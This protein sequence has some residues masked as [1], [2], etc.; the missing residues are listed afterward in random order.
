MA[1]DKLTGK[2]TR[3]EVT[4]GADPTPVVDPA[5]IVGIDESPVIS[6]FDS[7]P[8]GTA[9]STPHSEV[10]KWRVE[11]QVEDGGPTHHALL[12]AIYADLGAGLGG[13]YN[14]T[15]SD[16]YEATGVERRVRYNGLRL[17]SVS[18]PTTRGS[19]KVVT[20]AGECKASNRQVL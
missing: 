20:I 15:K 7:N 3:V 12:D 19:I 10:N 5:D 16:L 6:T 14:V 18:E 9:D 11:I 2:S 4:K 17:Q 8:L 1:D 13:D